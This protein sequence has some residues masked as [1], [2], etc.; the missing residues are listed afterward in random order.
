MIVSRGALISAFL[1]WWQICV[2][3]DWFCFF[4]THVCLT[5]YSHQ[6]M[7]TS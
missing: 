7:G 3:L 5:Y 6:C 4:H 1:G 2:C